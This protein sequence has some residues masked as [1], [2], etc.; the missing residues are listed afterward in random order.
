MVVGGSVTRTV[1]CFLRTCALHIEVQKRATHDKM[2]N[3]TG[4]WSKVPNLLGGDKKF[5]CS[6]CPRT[7]GTGMIDYVT[8]PKVKKSIV[9]AP[10]HSFKVSVLKG[11]VEASGVARK[12]VS[13]L[14]LER[15]LTLASEDI[16]FAH[17]P[18]QCALYGKTYSSSTKVKCHRTKC[19]LVPFHGISHSWSIFTDF[20]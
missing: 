8:A 3:T 10:F 1:V 14:I 9:G 19:P 5:Y 11:H 7:R 12:K 4:I 6:K 16:L 20:D 13:S 18:T 15:R 2:H 17:P